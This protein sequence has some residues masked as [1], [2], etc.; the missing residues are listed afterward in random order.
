MTPIVFCKA[1]NH[2]NES[3]RNLTI[4]NWIDT[5][6]KRNND[7]E[8]IVIINDEHEVSQ[9]DIEAFHNYAITPVL[10]SRRQENKPL[11]AA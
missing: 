5:Q 2:V 9:N 3:K 8:L 1:I 7:G 10:F 4:F 11:F 6:E